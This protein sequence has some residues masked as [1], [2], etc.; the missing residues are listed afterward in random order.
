M[1][2]NY[3]ATDNRTV[4]PS[5]NLADTRGY[6]P[7]SFK[8]IV[9]IG[10]TWV[11]NSFKD[12]HI[13]Q[14]NYDLWFRM[15]GIHVRWYDPTSQSSVYGQFT[16]GVGG[17]GYAINDIVECSTSSTGT[18]LF[19]IKVLTVTGSAVASLIFNEWL[20]P[21][22]VNSATVYEAITTTGK[23]G[24]TIKFNNWARPLSGMP[25][26]LT[27]EV[28]NTKTVLDEELDK[29]NFTTHPNNPGTNMFFQGN[30]ANPPA[31]TNPRFIMM[32]EPF[33]ALCN[34]AYPITYS[35]KLDDNDNPLKATQMCG[36]TNFSLQYNTNLSVFEYVYA[37]TPYATEF[38]TTTAT[39]GNNAV[40]IIYPAQDKVNNFDCFSGINITSWARPDYLVGSF[41]NDKVRKI[42][43]NL[44][45]CFLS[46]INP[47]RDIANSNSYDIIGSRFNDKLGFDFDQIQ[48]Q[49]SGIT[50]FDF[51]TRTGELQ[52]NGTTGN[53]LDISSSV[54]ATRQ[55]TE[56]EP[57]L[58][59]HQ[60][61]LNGTGNPNRFYGDLI[62]MPYS[63]DSG[64][65]T[66]NSSDNF[67]G[68]KYG[69]C[70]GTFGSIGGERI[71]NNIVSMGLQNTTGSQIKY[72][73][74]TAPLSFD[75]CFLGK[76]TSYTIAC[77]SSSIRAT[78]LPE[79]T[80]NGYYLVVSDIIDSDGFI[81]S[82][83]GG[84]PTNIV[85]IIMKN[86]TSS[87]FIISYQ[88]PIQLY[89]PKDVIISQIRT[90]IIDNNFEPPVNIGKN[91][92]VIYAIENLNPSIERKFPSIEDIQQQ[93]YELMDLVNN[94]IKKSIH[95]TGAGIMAQTASDINSLS[96]ALTR[97]SYAQTHPIAQIRNKILQF[98]LPSM[99][100]AEKHRFMTETSEGQ[101]LSDDIQDFNFMNQAVE[102]VVNPVAQSTALGTPM[103]DEGIYNAGQTELRADELRNKLKS[104][105]RETQRNMSRRGITADQFQNVGEG[106]AIKQV[107]DAI[108]MNYMAERD[109]LKAQRQN[110]VD[111]LNNFIL[112]EGVP[113]FD[114]YEDSLGATNIPP[115]K[116]KENYQKLL[117][118]DYGVQ[119]YEQYIKEK[120]LRGEKIYTQ[121]NVDKL[122]SDFDTAYEKAETGDEQGYLLEPS[123]LQDDPSL[124]E[125]LSGHYS[126][127]M[128]GQKDLDRKQRIQKANNQ[129]SLTREKEYNKYYKNFKPSATNSQPL[130]FKD[131]QLAV[132][133]NA[134][135][136]YQ[137][138][139]TND[140]LENRRRRGQVEPQIPTMGDIE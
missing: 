30:Q 22:T 49:N 112:G 5:T 16:I 2:I 133:E 42:L 17:T 63:F 108:N 101:A 61:G 85:A 18:P 136:I 41:T 57:A 15:G 121:K 78:Q 25:K 100:E 72:D 139:P 37:H 99:S 10:G 106:R 36:S 40:K 118:Q 54:I 124:Q 27:S 35:N 1:K 50:E 44:W 97:P 91:S 130:S 88:S 84:S 55:A 92:A 90:K 134:Y 34:P 83:N 11:E 23:S 68:V 110:Y 38:N 123:V 116:I 4:K 126:Y 46:S 129:E 80:T 14:G 69:Y 39:G 132:Y 79:K 111:Q 47:D 93:D 135:P 120:A 33:R 71:T 45:M 87:D 60:G 32:E 31:N 59:N 96:T 53:D 76:W 89:F 9:Y 64:T 117:E 127:G 62:I 7:N 114:E 138:R 21:F 128:K 3:P 26:P 113:T 102:D 75:P 125:R 8:A 119:T 109:G 20:D 94:Q 73:M 103:I 12:T 58:E 137:G 115:H 105:I 66:I 13:A 95:K 131:Y 51:T 70:G 6:Y 24:L 52:F 56:Q 29:P 82:L 107:R 86:Y 65:Q 140:V 98:D 104:A 74:L 122:F 67:S 28:A 77:G 19:S 43:Q 48:N 81:L